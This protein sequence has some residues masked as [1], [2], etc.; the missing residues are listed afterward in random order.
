MASF[1][2]DD[3]KAKEL[4][5]TVSSLVSHFV[6]FIATQ[7]LNSPGLTLGNFTLMQMDKDII[8]SFK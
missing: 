2:F 3:D 4:A 5:K 1:G 8:L 6:H 7:A